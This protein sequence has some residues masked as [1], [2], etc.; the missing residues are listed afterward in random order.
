MIAPIL[1]RLHNDPLICQVSL[2]FQ[3][4]SGAEG[5]GIWGQGVG[6]RLSGVGLDIRSL[7]IGFRVYGFS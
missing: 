1:Y 2:T 6:L 5:F 7:G 3:V 4:V